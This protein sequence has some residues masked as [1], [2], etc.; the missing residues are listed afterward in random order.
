MAL[1]SNNEALIAVL[2]SAKILEA[3]QFVA[4]SN[5]QLVTSQLNE[6][7]QARDER[8]AAYLAHA[9]QLLPQFEKVEVK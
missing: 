5:S 2:N 9:K 6:D 1:S 4:F 8:I 3:R 7:Y